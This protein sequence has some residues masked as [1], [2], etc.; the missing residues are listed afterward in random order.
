MKRLWILAALAAA[1][2]TSGA[3]D[4]LTLSAR[5]SA[6]NR[7]AL[8]TANGA[9]D[10]AS[11]I[12]VTRVRTVIRHLRLE[13]EDDKSETEISAGPLLLDV[14][15]TNL[16]GALVELVTNNVPA[17]TYDKLKLEIHVIDAA[18]ASQSGFQ[19][20]VDRAV[21]VLI[22]GKLDKQLSPNCT[23][24]TQDPTQCSFTFG[25]ALEAELEQEGRF[26][27]GGTASNITLNIDASKWFQAANGS[28]LIPL[29]PGAQSAIEANIKASFSA[30][31]DD[32]ENGEADDGEHNDG[33]HDD[34]EH[35]DGGHGDAGDDGERDGG[36]P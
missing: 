13:R 22:E 23:P 5:L 21:S 19:D 14:G 11:G 2:C 35:P 36:I 6:A 25:S 8:P 10:V 32:N 26:Q 1:T 27:L 12:K 4:S 29:D 24:D 28:V 30:F 3:K 9:A 16:G 34:G 18:P 31:E 20:L 17:G 33:G 15:G 7:Q